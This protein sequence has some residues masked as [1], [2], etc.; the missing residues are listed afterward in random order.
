MVNEGSNRPSATTSSLS[1]NLL[2]AFIALEPNPRPAPIA[3]ISGAAS[4]TLTSS[5]ILL[6][7]IAV[8]SPAMPPPTMEIRLFICIL[9]YFNLINSLFMGGQLYKKLSSEAFFIQPISEPPVVSSFTA[10]QQ[11]TV[12]CF[13]G[14]LFERVPEH[15]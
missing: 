7:A 1:P 2:K 8:V 6:R 3:L 15:H 4:N 13:G 10:S 14:F 5:P 12:L 11:P 9:R